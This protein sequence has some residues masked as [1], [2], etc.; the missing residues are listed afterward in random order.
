LPHSWAS[1]WRFDGCSEKENLHS[2]LT[3]P[4]WILRLEGAAILAASSFFYARGHFGWWLFALLFLA[5]DLFM[6][7]YLVNVRVGAISYNLVHTLVGPLV[8]LLV[9]R[10]AT[11]PHLVPCGL[12]W[13]AHLGF[14]RM[15]GYG[16]K[17]PTEFR[18]TH[19]QHV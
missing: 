11:A 18:D 1:N 8:L 3:H 9:A 16:L 17:Y 2:M 7:G 12:I 15:L 4:R 14:D 5:P 13:L 10:L 19:L 6:L